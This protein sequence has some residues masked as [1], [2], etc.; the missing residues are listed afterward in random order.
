M[1]SVP[2][3][4]LSVDSPAQHRFLEA[5]SKNSTGANFLGRGSFG[6]VFKASYKGT[7]IY[8]VLLCAPKK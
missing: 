1:L 5:I 3:Q 6:V 2:C 7:C 8:T 4:V